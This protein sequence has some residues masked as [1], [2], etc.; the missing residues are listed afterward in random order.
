MREGRSSGCRDQWPMANGFASTEHPTSNPEPRTVLAQGFE[1]LRGL[2]G[3]HST[4][5][6]QHPA[7]PQGAPCQAVPNYRKR[8]RRIAAS[9]G[10]SAGDEH[11]RGLS[12]AT[13]GPTTAALNSS[14]VGPSGSARMP[15]LISRPTRRES[16]S[17]RIRSFRILRKSWRSTS[18]MKMSS[19]RSPRSITLVLP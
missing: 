15:F 19:R 6:I 14:L 10:P 16:S 17:E 18:S 3:G 13:P 9:L 7:L 2:A 5:K 12:H 1:L 4:S 8:L 11:R